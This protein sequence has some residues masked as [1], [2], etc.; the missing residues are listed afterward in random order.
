VRTNQRHAFIPRQIA[1]AQKRIKMEPHFL[2]H[3]EIQ[4]NGKGSLAN[5]FFA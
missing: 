3:D 1:A 2:H 4:L 5:P